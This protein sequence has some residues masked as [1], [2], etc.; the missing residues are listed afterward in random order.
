ML[1]VAAGDAYTPPFIWSGVFEDLI[2]QEEFAMHPL[3]SFWAK[4]GNETWPDKYHPVIC[5][6][7]D[8]AKVVAG[9]TEPGLLIVEAPMGEGRSRPGGTRPH[10]PR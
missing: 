3:L 2:S 4:L 5:H 8:V 10:L 7:I 6:L 1:E 9:M